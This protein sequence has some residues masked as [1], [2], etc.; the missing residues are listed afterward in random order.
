MFV[1]A[2]RAKWQQTQRRRERER[3]RGGT[4]SSEIPCRHYLVGAS[5]HGTAREN[6][7]KLKMMTRNSKPPLPLRHCH[8]RQQTQARP[9]CTSA[10]FPPACSRLSPLAMVAMSAMIMTPIAF[11]PRI[12]DLWSSRKLER[13]WNPLARGPPPSSRQHLR[14]WRQ[15]GGEPCRGWKTTGRKRWLAACIVSYRPIWFPTSSL[16]LG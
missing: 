15:G 8:R 13:G 12:S 16:C 2:V 6:P 7:D 9:S 10:L 1:R 4:G 3:E 14:R 5:G 11:S